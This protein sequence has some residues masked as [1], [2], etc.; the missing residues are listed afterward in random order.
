MILS[1]VGQSWRAASSR[2]IHLA[3]LLLGLGAGVSGDEMAAKPSGEPDGVLAA[4]LGELLGEGELAGWVAAGEAG[5]ATIGGGEEGSVVGVTGR[6]RRAGGV[7]RLRPRRRSR[8]ATD[9]AEGSLG[10]A[11]GAGETLDLPRASARLMES[12][13]AVRTSRGMFSCSGGDV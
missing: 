3:W 7:G 8:V 12:W 1:A 11:G 5:A 2:C 10:V 9:E 13:M 4:D 6:R